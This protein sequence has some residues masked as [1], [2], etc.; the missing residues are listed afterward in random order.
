MSNSP[1]FPSVLP[2]TTFT[3]AKG[4]VIGRGMSCTVYQHKTQPHLVIKRER[5]VGKF[6]NV[7]EYHIWHQICC[8]KLAEWFAPVYAISPCGQ[9]IIQAKTQPI[10]ADQL[11]SQVPGLFTDF[12]QNNWGM[13]EGRPVCHDYGFTIFTI[14]QAL[15]KSQF[16][17]YL[18]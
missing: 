6:Q 13:L 4:K 3:K 12:K 15:K 16:G 1:A 2:V 5:Q 8:M 7:N 9:F 17:K 11:P 18:Q 14:R 10:T